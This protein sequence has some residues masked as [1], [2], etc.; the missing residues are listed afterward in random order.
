[1][2][3]I[4]MRIVLAL[5]FACLLW[6]SFQK[7]EPIKA[8]LARELSA[9]IDPIET[10]DQASFL[11]ELTSR[12]NAASETS[13]KTPLALTASTDLQFWLSQRSINGQLGD[14]SAITSAIKDTM[15]T[16]AEVEA[17]EFKARRQT[18]LLDEFTRWIHTR[19]PGLTHLATFLIRTP[20]EDRVKGITIACRKLPRFTPTLLNSDHAEFFSTCAFCEDEH[21]VSVERNPL[22]RFLHCPSCS[23]NYGILF[24]DLEGRYHHAN[25]F[26]T[27][28][29]P[30]SFV[31]RADPDD[32][33]GRHFEMTTIWKAVVDHCRY[34]TDIL[35]L[36]GQGEQWQ[37][38]SQ[39]HAYANGDCEDTSILLVDWL[40]ARGFD[41]RVALGWAQTAG[42]ETTGHAWAVC[43]IGREEFIL[44]STPHYYDPQGP[45]T[46]AE[47]GNLY[48]PYALLNRG[49]TYFRRT[50]G[51][52][53]T[54]YS[55]HDWEAITT[56]PLSPEEIPKIA[57]TAGSV[58]TAHRWIHGRLHFNDLS[59]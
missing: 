13:K 57:E 27:G 7:R 8:F 29:E 19:P 17:I 16:F 30:P 39:T 50:E 41:A 49:T 40:I 36:A 28:F 47:I 38:A 48:L 2:V 4:T 21:P 32:L 11:A 24:Q 43:R 45:P 35:G 59:R 54:Y 1:M 9:L 10:L 25:Q 26:L 51:W 52:T 31:P 5:F 46:N 6:M 3:F 55:S 44:E 22:G 53:P 56:P 34:E 33:D 15:P 58:A 23:R 20:D 14:L 18:E 12:A 42:G 37:F